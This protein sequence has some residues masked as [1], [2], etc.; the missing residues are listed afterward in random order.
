M[1]R[2]V[3]VGGVFRRIEADG[4]VG[5]GAEVIDL[6]RLDLLDD[7]R[8]VGRV[9]QVAIVQDQV[10]MQGLGVLVNVID[11]LGIERRRAAFQ[12]MHDVAFFQQQFRQVRT[13]LPGNP[14]NKRD[15]FHV[16]LPNNRRAKADTRTW[17]FVKNGQLFRYGQRQVMSGQ[18]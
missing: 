9:R 12:A 14:G 5:L 16:Y 15:F 7:A 18:L 6:V 17:V 2:G 10:F 1:P 13:I 4:H 3:Y 11:A 8:Q